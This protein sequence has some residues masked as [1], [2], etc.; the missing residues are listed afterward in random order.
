MVFLLKQVLFGFFFDQAVASQSGQK[1]SCLHRDTSGVLVLLNC[2]IRSGVRQGA[3]EPGRTRATL[4]LER[5]RL[6]DLTA[7]FTL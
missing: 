6:H 1:E 5:Y 2:V 7:E 3:T 4:C